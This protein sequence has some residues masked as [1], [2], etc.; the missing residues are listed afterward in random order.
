MRKNV[1]KTKKIKKVQKLVIFPVKYI[2]A[3]DGIEP[4]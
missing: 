2:E 3:K 1:V 4:S